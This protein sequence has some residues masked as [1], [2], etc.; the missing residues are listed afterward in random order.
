[1]RRAADDASVR[2]RALEFAA[3]RLGRSGADVLF[4]VWIATNAKTPGTR[5]AR[6]W[7]DSPAVRAG[8]GPGVVLAL[9][10]RVA[11]TCSAALA[12]LPRMTELGDERSLVPLRRFQAMT[13]CGFLGLSDCYP[14][15][16]GTDALER[17]VASVAARP[18]PKFAG[19]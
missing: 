9:E 15:L 3:T 14:C 4:D 13:G 19:K 8:A 7:L 6:K 5:A 12:L 2:E 10:S 11:K 16:R 18:A 1:V 17:A